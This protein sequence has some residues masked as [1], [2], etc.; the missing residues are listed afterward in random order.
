M[1]HH[2]HSRMENKPQLSPLVSIIQWCYLTCQNYSFKVF[3]P[4]PLRNKLHI[5]AKPQRLASFQLQWH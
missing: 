3:I 1:N 2:S 5:Q 4:T